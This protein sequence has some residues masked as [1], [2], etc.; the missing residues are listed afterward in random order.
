MGSHKGYPQQK[1][2][3]AIA[4]ENKIDPA[5]ERYRQL[6]DINEQQ[7]NGQKAHPFHQV[8]KAAMAN[9]EQT[10]FPQRKD[11]DYKY[12]RVD[13]IAK[14]KYADA[15]KASVS[16]EVAD[17]LAFEEL[18]TYHLVFVNG[19][20]QHQ[21]SNIGE[22]QKGLVI[23]DYKS[24]Y[25][26]KEA[27]SFL[28]Q[29]IKSDLGKNAFVDLNSAFAKNGLFVYVAKNT[30][31]EK[32]IH[33]SHLTVAEGEEF[34]VHPQLAVFAEQSAEVS[35]IETFN[36]LQ[37]GAYFN[38]PVSRFVLKANANVKHY[39]LQNESS[40]GNQINNTIVSQ[41]RDSVYSSY[42]ADLG[43]KVVRNNLSSH[44]QDSGTNTN[45]YGVY[46]GKGS[47]HIDNQSFLDHAFPHCE[48]NQLYKGI[49]DEQSR[50]V[51]NGKVTVQPDAQKTNAY[52]QNSSLVLSDTAV[53]DSKP[54]LEIFADDVK[55][56]HGATIGQL[57]EDSIY[58][59]RTRGMNRDQAK[60]TLQFAFLAEVL[61]HFPLESVRAK[62]AEM[63][64]KKLKK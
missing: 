57:D 41:D 12:T 1:I 59:L 48:S 54:Q 38:N 43:G 27:A 13:K 45:M 32:P 28:E 44:L 58:Y 40:S 55:C 6:F 34:I 46:L 50:G 62:I 19:R 31:V 51:F 11:E 10:G 26:H 21:L 7:L 35:I 24:V 2:K 37:E 60:A 63:I 3:M 42:V 16:Q 25:A 29:V 39:K 64:E 36:A 53:M 47:Q 56:S 18:D 9:L 20:Y 8:R 22:T 61:T 5:V 14:V 52:Q 49:L 4:I 33:I 23:G 15:P 30:T 17:G